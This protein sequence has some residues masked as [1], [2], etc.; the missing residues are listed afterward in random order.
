MP[1]F[2]SPQFEILLGAITF[3]VT[4]YLAVTIL[5]Q[6]KSSWTNRLF[7]LLSSTLAGYV[8]LNYVSLH[9]PGG[10]GASQLFWIRAVMSL[11]SWF[12]PLLFLLAW[13]FP[14][15]SWRLPKPYTAAILSFMLLTSAVSLTPLVF[16]SM[17]Y[18]GGQ[19]VP[20][21]GYGMPLFFLDFIGMIVASFAVLVA[22]Y[23]RAN[24]ENRSQQKAFVFGILTSFSLLIAFV[25]LSVVLFKTSN[26]VFLGPVFFS[27]L[28]FSIAYAMVKHQL[29]GIRILAARLLIA[30]LWI[31]FLARFFSSSG[32][33]EFLENGL[34]FLMVLLLGGG[35]LRSMYAELQ[36]RMKD[37]EKKH[38]RE[39]REQES[40]FFSL[41]GKQL[42]SLLGGFQAFITQIRSG[43]LCRP[44]RRLTV[45]LEALEQDHR[46]MN[47]VLEIFSN[48]AGDEKRVVCAQ[49]AVHL[50]ELLADVIS[51]FERA[52]KNKGMTIVYHPSELPAQ[53]IADEEKLRHVLENLVDNAVKYSQSGIVRV[54]A[55]VKEKGVAIS[56]ADQGVGFAP[57]ESKRLWQK[58]YRGAYARTQNIGGTGLGLYISK[59]FVEAHG[60]Y[61]WA[62]SPGPNQGSEF[63]LWIPLK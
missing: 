24:S 50:D 9:P 62:S 48:I 32:T 6:D 61:V 31:V 10:P 40:G 4:A 60:G 39:M 33:G 23:R 30:L 58:F 21:P 17:D 57:L 52:A 49:D 15:R 13:N 55:G 12:G 1:T 25:F 59:I 63:G 22:R 44:T 5:L 35:L 36:M 37:Q 14:E 19:P 51:S 7:F 43:E 16:R 29:F 26:L 20:V 41:T 34:I 42:Q 38:A 54:S 27:I 45:A 8:I 46:R 28:M 18:T 53:I 47:T 2:I 56:V 11:C 3:F